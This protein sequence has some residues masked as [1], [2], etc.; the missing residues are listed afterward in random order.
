MRNYKD[1]FLLCLMIVFCVLLLTACESGAVKN[2][3]VEV[4]SSISYSQIKELAIDYNGLDN[5]NYLIDG[6]TLSLDGDVSVV[7]CLGSNLVSYGSGPFSLM[8]FK[9]GEVITS[10]VNYTG[11]YSDYQFSSYNYVYAN[12]GL[13][14]VIWSEYDSN[15]NVNRVFFS[16]PYGKV[17]NLL[18]SGSST[19][20]SYSSIK[21]LSDYTCFCI[22]DNYDNYYCFKYVLNDNEYKVQTMDYAEFEAA[23]NQ[24]NLT[25]EY[26]DGLI[27]Q[28][29]KKGNIYGYIH[30]SDD[31]YYLYDSKKV[32][33]NS[34]NISSY[35]FND[36]PSIELE[37]KLVFFKS[38]TYYD[39]ESNRSSK[40][41]YKCKCLEI[42]CSNGNVY[43][44]DDFKYFIVDVDEYDISNYS[45]YSCVKY[46]ELNERR[47]LDSILKCAILTDKL[48][49]SDSFVYD[50][51]EGDVYALESGKYLALFGEE[52]YLV[53]RENRTLLKGVEIEAIN[54]GRIIFT[55]QNSK[56]Y[57]CDAKGFEEKIK[58][59]SDGKTYISSV[60]Y[61]GS[62]IVLDY[63]QE[64]D[65]YVKDLYEIQSKFLYLAKMGIYVEKDKIYIG[66]GKI[67]DFSS[68]GTD[69]SIYSIDG[70]YS[71]DGIRVYRVILS[72]GSY[73]YFSYNRVIQ[74][75]N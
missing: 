75:I 64:K 74:T 3:K 68:S 38:E 28:Y 55:N 31:I 45:K 37:K 51:F 53:S 14:I 25:P 35:G 7:R 30:I 50:G 8:N 73:Y 2:E 11:L 23:S 36:S 63:S 13:P 54:N 70:L 58:D 6:R 34:V 17:L 33:L 62:L 60:T 22:K 56:Y 24:A 42:D 12:S 48:D 66:N 61:N 69:L 59:L 39:N 27:P 72:D 16:D 47:E 52:Y 57:M 67:M 4:P 19:S 1:K 44:N 41:S 15:Y 10:K 5:Y 21:Y 49:F 29:D 32:F 65:C 46:C 18:E 26:E 40:T 43:F 71:L 9:T 20:I